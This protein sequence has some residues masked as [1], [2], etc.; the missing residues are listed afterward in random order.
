MHGSGLSKKGSNKLVV[1]DCEDG[2]IELI[3][4][5]IIEMEGEQL[6]REACLS[7]PGYFGNVKKSSNRCNKNS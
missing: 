4:P 1:M 6:G 2:L 3:N 7:F 5:E